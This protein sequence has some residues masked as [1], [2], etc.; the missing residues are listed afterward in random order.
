MLGHHASSGPRVFTGQVKPRPRQSSLHPMTA[1]L[2][3]QIPVY[4]LISPCPS[5]GSSLSLQ[6][7]DVH[8]LST[9]HGRNVA[10]ILSRRRTGR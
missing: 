9:V 4:K 1:Q 2:P 7:T 3:S 8:A 5:P 10:R 6:W